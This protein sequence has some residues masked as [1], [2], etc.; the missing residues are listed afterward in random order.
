MK[1]DRDIDLKN[2][3]SGQE[4]SSMLRFPPYFI[5]GTATSA[6]QIEGE[7]NTEWKGFRGRDGT[8]LGNESFFKS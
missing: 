8:L 5:L 7:G 4:T 6:S 2:N 3:T 1:Q